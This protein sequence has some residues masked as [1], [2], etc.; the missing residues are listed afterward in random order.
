[1]PPEI[2]REK[3]M[4]VMIRTTAL[5]VGA[6]T[7]VAALAVPGAASHAG[8][9]EVRAATARY[10]QP[11]AAAADGY[12]DTGDCVVAPS[13]GM[14]VHHVRFDRID[15]ELDPTAPEILLF[16]PTTHRDR[17]VGVEYAAIAPEEEPPSMFGEQ[18]DKLVSNGDGTAMWVLH[19][20]IWRQNPNGTFA[21]FNPR[22][23]CPVPAAMN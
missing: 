7:A 3:D 19:A 14:G 17:L 5:A 10:H 20:W 22:V 2:H 23:S 8:L 13:G 16:E 11:G 4:H 1:V 18:F 6:L 12:V 21:P 15:G 9:A